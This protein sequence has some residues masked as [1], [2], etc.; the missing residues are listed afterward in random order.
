MLPRLFTEAQ[1]ATHAAGAAGAD[2]AGQIHQR[3][4]NTLV[5][6]GAADLGHVATR[7]VLR[8]AGVALD[9]LR[10]ATARCTLGPCSPGAR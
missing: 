10:A 2:R 5:R 3:A 4:A 9:P 6:L 8:L 7:E 1:A